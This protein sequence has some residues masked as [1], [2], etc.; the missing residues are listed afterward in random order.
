M[1]PM[2]NVPRPL[3]RPRV[4][5]GSTPAGATAWEPWTVAASNIRRSRETFRISFQVPIGFQVRIDTS[6]EGFTRVPHYFASL[7][8]PLVSLTSKGIRVGGRWEHIEG[9]SIDGFTYRAIVLLQE[10]IES[11]VQRSGQHNEYTLVEDAWAGILK[12]LR[13]GECSVSWL[14]IE[15]ES[16]SRPGIRPREVLRGHIR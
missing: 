2:P 15:P 9:A 16:Q 7:Q 12:Q 14:A 3:A 6:A 4:A 1:L 10:P 13:E 8:G 11:A 5:S